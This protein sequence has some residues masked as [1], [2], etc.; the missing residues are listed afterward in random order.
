VTALAVGGWLGVSMNGA[1]AWAAAGG[2][3]GSAVAL[4][5]LRVGLRWRG[6]V[7]PEQRDLVFTQLVVAF[8]VLGAGGGAVLYALQASPLPAAV[9]VGIGFGILAVILLGLWRLRLAPRWT[10]ELL[11]VMS[12]P[13]GLLAWARGKASK[14]PP[15]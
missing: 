13:R 5:L 9:V 15:G 7:P 12:E 10:A 8:V 11:A 2:V 14:P 6:L 4:T 3:A 1:T